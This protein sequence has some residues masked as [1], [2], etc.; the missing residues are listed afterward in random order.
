MPTP[1]DYSNAPYPIRDDI[2]QAHREAWRRI[3][4][5]GAW[6]NGAERVAICEEARLARSCSFCAERKRALS[7]YSVSGSHSS[8][9]D[10]LPTAAI[11]AV[12]RVITD[13]ARLSREWIDELAA[14]GV[15]DAHYAEL[16]GL[17]VAI[18]SIDGFHRGLGLEL[19]PLP[20]PEAGEPS[21][22]RPSS[23]KPS[24][25]WLPTISARDSRATDEADL[26]EGLPI[27]PNVI[28]AMSLAPDSVRLLKL[29]GAVHYMREKDVGNPTSNGGRALNRAQIELVAARVSAINECFF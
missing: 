9:G 25:G 18:A 14:G 8:S 21:H 12:H 17:V 11:D 29:L 16:L 19:E 22:Y 7:P 26:Y 23:A 10:I 3:A 1:F 13:P 28:A 4:A 20:S 6:W 15:S 24:G 5:P 2:A 27:A